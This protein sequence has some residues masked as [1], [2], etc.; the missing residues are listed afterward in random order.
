MKR[1]LILSA[2]MIF[3]TGVINAQ[4]G[5]PELDYIKQAYSKE[6]KTIV[7]EYMNLDAADSAKFWPVYAKYEASREKLSIARIQLIDEYVK[8]VAN[9]SPEAASRIGDGVLK[10]TISVDKLNLEYFGKMKKAIGAVK[11]AQ[12][13][14]L[15]TYLQTTWRAVVQDNI[16]LIGELDKTQKEN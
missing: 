10:N 4:S 13:I 2:A 9:L 6:K 1:L 14:Q 5:D 15:E 3:F 7:D 16:P 11:A 8:N 12:Y